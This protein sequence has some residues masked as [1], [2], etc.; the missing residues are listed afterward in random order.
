MGF[1]CLGLW[2]KILGIFSN[3]RVSH[4]FSI[5]YTMSPILSRDFG[6]GQGTFLPPGAT[7][8]PN[9]IDKPMQEGP[10]DSHPIIPRILTETLTAHENR[11]T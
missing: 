3:G 2:L 9:G 10:Q 5:D 6:M 8:D 1:I 7:D 11:Q 4:N